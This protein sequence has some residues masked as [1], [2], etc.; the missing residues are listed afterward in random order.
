MKA[1]YGRSTIWW[2]LMTAHP[3]LQKRWPRFASWFYHWCWEKHRA[4]V[5]RRLARKA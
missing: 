1:H 2:R 4:A 3:L 5:L